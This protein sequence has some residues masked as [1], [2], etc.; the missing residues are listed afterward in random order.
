MLDA[1]VISLS[2]KLSRYLIICAKHLHQAHASSKNCHRKEFIKVTTLLSSGA[3]TSK[4]DKA[5]GMFG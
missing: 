3:L 2:S 4:V 1:E 5:F